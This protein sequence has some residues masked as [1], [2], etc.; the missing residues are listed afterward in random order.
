MPRVPFEE[1][2][3]RGRLWVFPAS[4]DLTQAETEA[5]LGA[6][7][8]FLAAWSAHGAPLR[9]ARELVERRFLLVGVDV[10]A[11]APSGCSIDALVNRLRA[12]GTEL[13]VS[14]I[15]HA[16]VW[17]RTDDGDVRTVS[18]RDFRALAGEG[19]VGPSLVVFDT[20]LTQV[21]Q[22]RQGGLER[23][24]SETWHAKAFFAAEG[25]R[26]ARG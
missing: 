6:V 21:G 9:S 15:D 12:L 7:D 22:R 5:L 13:D 25:A 11:E 17:F 19:A 26:P 1:L 24:A 16:P 23:P 8:D 14:L 18:R 20:S 2:P 10:D 3:D 4:R